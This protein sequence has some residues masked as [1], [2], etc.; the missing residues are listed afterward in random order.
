MRA[1]F[2]L[3]L[4][5][6]YVGMAV[7]VAVHVLALIL[8]RTVPTFLVLA[9][10]VGIVI[11]GVPTT[12]RMRHLVNSRY[13]NDFGRFLWSRTPPWLR[14]LTWGAF[15]YFVLVFLRF[16]ATHQ[17]SPTVVSVLPSAT[18]VMFSAG[19]LSA[20]AILASCLRFQIDAGYTETTESRFE[21]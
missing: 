14:W 3:L 10:H 21:R 9:L 20:Y 7:S 5:L 19:W 18:L 2:K 11:V 13:S 4:V 6:C 8:D 12:V 16:A 1:L 15:G 17:A